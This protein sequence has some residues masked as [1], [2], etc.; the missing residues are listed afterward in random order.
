MRRFCA[1]A[2]ANATPPSHHTW[3]VRTTAP[4]SADA[5][6]PASPA[7]A[8]AAVPAVLPR[9]PS[10]ARRTSACTCGSSRRVSGMRAVAARTRRRSAPSTWR[11]TAAPDGS[12]R[13]V[14]SS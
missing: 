10:S 14:Q 7:T 9:C 6:R 13:A 2:S 12:R 1:R 4:S 5:S 11:A 3:P 8:T